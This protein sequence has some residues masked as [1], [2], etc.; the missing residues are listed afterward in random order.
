MC[1]T[2]MK[3][4]SNHSN[5]TMDFLSIEWPN[6]NKIIGKSRDLFLSTH[7]HNYLSM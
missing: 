4:Y 1:K 3:L 5:K 2:A 7:T 6:E